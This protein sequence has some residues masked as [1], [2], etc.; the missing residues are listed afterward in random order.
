MICVARF[1]SMV[2]HPF[3]SGAPGLALGL[4]ESPSETKSWPYPTPAYHVIVDRNSSLKT[5][6]AQAG[7]SHPSVT[8]GSG[9]LLWSFFLLLVLL[10]LSLLCVFAFFLF[11]AFILVF[12]SAFVTHGVTPFRLIF[13]VSRSFWHHNSEGGNRTG[14]AWLMPILA[15]WHKNSHPIVT[16]L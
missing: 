14:M 6:P 12:F 2:F 8:D 15:L 9:F 7:M 16:I 11:L 13:V 3:C 1:C 5:H 10:L 4:V